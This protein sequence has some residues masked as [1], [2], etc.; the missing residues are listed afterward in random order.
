MNTTE[1]VIEN[2]KADRPSFYYVAEVSVLFGDRKTS[3]FM[4]KAGLG[5]SGVGVWKIMT[6]SYSPGLEVDEKRVLRAFSEMQRTTNEQGTDLEV[7][8][9]NIISL[10]RH[11]T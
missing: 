5:L 1:T 3:T 9:F 4:R 7:L 11:S 2:V 6:V 8:A 10:T